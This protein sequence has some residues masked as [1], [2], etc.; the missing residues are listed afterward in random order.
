M[1]E[2]LNAAEQNAYDA[3]CHELDATEQ[4]DG[5]LERIRE[6]RAAIA[7]TETEPQRLKEKET[8]LDVRIVALEKRLDDK[9]RQ[10]LGIGS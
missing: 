8:E 1:G 5:N 7:F 10:L 9:T 2:I 4:L 6:L 3:G